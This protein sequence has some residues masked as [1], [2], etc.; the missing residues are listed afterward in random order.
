MRRITILLMACFTLVATQA[1]TLLKPTNP[2]EAC[3][4][5]W[6]NYRKADVL[7]KTGW[8]LFIFG[9][10]GTTACSIG[11][12]ATLYKHEM[13]PAELATNRACFS[14]AIISCG[15]LASSVPCLIVGQVRRKDAIRTINEYQCAPD[16]TCDELRVSYKR[17]NDTWKA[18]W[19]LFGSG[20]GL[21]IVGINLTFTE[22]NTMLYAG[23]GLIS[24]GSGAV[25]T[26]VPCLAFG[27]VQ[28]KSAAKQYH[29]YCVDQ[30]P[31]T[32]NL[33]TSSNGLGIAM[34]F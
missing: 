21:L 32:F 10:V 30:P 4:Q 7:W 24:I 27:Q 22:N 16:L 3:A 15:V 14:L 8:G 17:A 33:Q 26:S 11:T 20:L 19:G 5:A 1:Q 34:N 25:I 6:N 31:L 29:Q 18:G 23:L 13:T 28:R 9:A 12:I 2:N